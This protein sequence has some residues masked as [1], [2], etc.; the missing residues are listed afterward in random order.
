MGKI[1]KKLPPPEKCRNEKLEKKLPP[2]IH[3]FPSFK[4]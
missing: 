4:I 2:H 1:M 3:K